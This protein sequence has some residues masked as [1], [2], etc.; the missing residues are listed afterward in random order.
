MDLYKSKKPALDV[1]GRKDHD[2]TH[3]VDNESSI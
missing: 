1:E 2:L 3:L